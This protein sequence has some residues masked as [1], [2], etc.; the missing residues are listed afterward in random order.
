MPARPLQTNFTAGEVSPQLDARI[1]YAR[2]KNGAERIKNGIVRTT[3]GVPRRAGTYF[4]HEVADS[5]KLAV[6]V[7]FVFSVQQAYALEF[8]A[9]T[10]RIFQDRAVLLGQG[11][12]SELVTNETFATTIND[13]TA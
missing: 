6:L 13:W 7:P 9:T 4:I 8:Q 1:D 3:G 12:G 11:D 10:I 5:T 2:Y